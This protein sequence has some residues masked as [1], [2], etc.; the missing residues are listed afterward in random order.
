[1]T[2]PKKAGHTY[3][4]EKCAQPIQRGAY[5]TTYTPLYG[6]KRYYHLPC[7]GQ[8]GQYMAERLTAKV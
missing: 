2:C 4:C 8:W 3:W 5:Y 6:T 1:M 7:E